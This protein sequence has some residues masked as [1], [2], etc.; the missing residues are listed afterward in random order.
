MAQVDEILSI[1]KDSSG[2]DPQ[3]WLR[4]F[5]EGLKNGEIA[6][7]QASL[8]NLLLRPQADVMALV[9]AL[10]ADPTFIPDIASAVAKELG[11]D[12]SNG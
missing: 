3:A 11:K 8:N 7:L 10:K 1:L 4:Q 12:L 2:S 9:A 6:T 5:L